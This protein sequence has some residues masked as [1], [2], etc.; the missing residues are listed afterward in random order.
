MVA[1]RLAG[2]GNQENKYSSKTLNDGRKE[3]FSTQRSLATRCVLTRGV[4][5]VLN[6]F[7]NL[8]P[9]WCTN[10]PVQNPYIV[11]R[12]APETSGDVSALHANMHVLWSFQSASPWERELFAQHAGAEPGPGNL[13]SPS[14]TPSTFLTDAVPMP[15]HHRGTSYTKEGT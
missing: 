13:G 9:F 7:K 5:W 1:R 8:V 11:A 10:R 12:H 14:C 15:M 3:L 4:A 6:L 2:S